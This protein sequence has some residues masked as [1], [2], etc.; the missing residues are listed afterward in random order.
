MN[1]FFIFI[2]IF[3]R[4]IF[5]YLLLLYNCYL[6]WEKEINKRIDKIELYLELELFSSSFA[7]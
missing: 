7:C 1:L 5:M 6:L 2:F 4:Y 3:I